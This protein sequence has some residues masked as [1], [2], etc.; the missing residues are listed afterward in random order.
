MKT[1]IYKEVMIVEVGG[2]DYKVK[3]KKT[4]RSY[5]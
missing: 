1:K 3:N 4:F 2:E 5:L